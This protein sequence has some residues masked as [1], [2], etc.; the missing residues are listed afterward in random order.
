MPRDAE[1]PRLRIQAH[2]HLLAVDL[3]TWRVSHASRGISAVLGLPEQ[4]LRGA[5]LPRLIGPELLDVWVQSL[6]W[7]GV[8]RAP[9]RFLGQRI[10]PLGRTADVVVQAHDGHLLVEFLPRARPGMGADDTPWLQ[11][12]AFRLG[13][14]P[15][16]EARMRLLADEM[17][18]LSQHRECQVWLPE[19]GSR[20][21]SPR[22]AAAGRRPLGLAQ[23]AGL[24]CDPLNLRRHPGQ[25]LQTRIVVDLQQDG[26]EVEGGDWDGAGIEDRLHLA[27]PV[28]GERRLLEAMGARSAVL[29][30]RWDGL[31]LACLLIAHSPEVLNPGL[32]AVGGIERL[33]L[34]DSL[35]GG[36]RPQT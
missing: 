12:A 25:S 22:W 2:G 1:I 24:S 29:A 35:L 27:L 23:R 20:A 30:K 34:V 9:Q 16:E 13:A 7:G 5:S 19:L 6:G 36:P 18:I 28:D 4:C 3:Q 15:S 26:R 8:S 10:D 33:L 17:R 11:Q 14:A 31:R 21:L 32:E